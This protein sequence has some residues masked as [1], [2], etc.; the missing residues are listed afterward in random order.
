MRLS[1][2]C[3]VQRQWNDKIT[4]G[5]SCVCACSW[6]TAFLRYWP[7]ILGKTLQV[8][9]AG[10]TVYLLAYLLA[11]ESS[12]VATSLEMLLHVNCCG[13][14][15]VLFLPWVQ[16]GDL[17]MHITIVNLWIIFMIFHEEWCQYCWGGHKAITCVPLCDF[18]HITVMRQ[19]WFFPWKATNEADLQLCLWEK[20]GNVYQCGLKE[21]KE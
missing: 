14:F 9:D 13:K 5:H 10:S 3:A 17:H 15:H 16:S 19:F 18:S 7:Q 21:D 6:S 20:I 12:N 2:P 8:C 11:I 1:L 4:A